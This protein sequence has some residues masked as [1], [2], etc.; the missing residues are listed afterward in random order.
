MEEGWVPWSSW[1]IPFQE[2][3]TGKRLNMAY[4]SQISGLV[5]GGELSPDFSLTMH[6]APLKA[7]CGF[8]RSRGGEAG[9]TFLI[10]G[11]CDSGKNGFCHF[12]YHEPWVDSFL[13]LL[14]SVRMQDQSFPISVGCLSLPIWVPLTPNRTSQPVSSMAGG[15]GKFPNCCWLKNAT[16]KFL[17]GG[18]TELLPQIRAFT[19]LW[20]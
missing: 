10:C 3:R 5:P 6:S 17:T 2:H 18:R 20:K 8:C 15:V 4:L 14:S 16:I 11:F 1:L 13:L 19:T 12:L 9:G 7:P